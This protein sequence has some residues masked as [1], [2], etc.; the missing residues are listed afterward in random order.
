MLD[1]LDARELIEIARREGREV[2]AVVN[3]K[4]AC[5]CGSVD[6]VRRR[7]SNGA[8]Q[9]GRQ[10]R[11]C[12]KWNAIKKSSLPLDATLLDFDESIREQHQR[13]VSELWNAIR[14]IQIEEREREHQERVDQRR[15][16]YRRYLQSETWAKIR[17]KA[18]DRDN[19]I[20]QGCLENRATEV[21]HKSYPEVLG[22]E[23]LF[24]LVSIC[25]EC[26]EKV[27]GK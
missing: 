27:H 4:T 22:T 5:D 23:P 16:D 9:Y 14:E 7:L 20:C 21:H 18:L 2:Y 24:D 15:D 19:W 3:E 12:G 26:H 17:R 11:N 6:Y 25:R 10:C 8:I 1:P 13:V